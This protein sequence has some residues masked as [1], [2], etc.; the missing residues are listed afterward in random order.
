LIYIYVD[1]GSKLYLHAIAQAKKNEEQY[2]LR[3]TKHNAGIIDPE[4]K[5]V[6][7]ENDDIRNLWLDA[8]VEA[9]EIDSDLLDTDEQSSGDASN[10]G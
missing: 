6:F 8:G 1:S 2:T 5:A 4:A 3:N 10:A 9:Y 7:C